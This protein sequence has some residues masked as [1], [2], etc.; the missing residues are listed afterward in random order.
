LTL[1][2]ILEIGGLSSER[3][4]TSPQVLFKLRWSESTLILFI[5]VE[6]GHRSK[7]EQYAG[8]SR[9]GS[10]LMAELK[11][12]PSHNEVSNALTDHLYN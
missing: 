10:G 3:D 12:G 8:L 6:K 11:A 5:C 4:G 1:V 9:D 7:V 2:V